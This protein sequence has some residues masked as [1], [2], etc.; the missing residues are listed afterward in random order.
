VYEGRAGMNKQTQAN[1][2]APRFQVLPSGIM[3]NNGQPLNR[4][5]ISLCLPLHRTSVRP[6]IDGSAPV[7]FTARVQPNFDLL[8]LPI[9]INRSLQASLGRTRLPEFF[10]NH[11]SDLILLLLLHGARGDRNDSDI[12][13]HG[14][15]LGFF[16]TLNGGLIS[17]DDTA[18]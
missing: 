18:R 4:G 16:R 13:T 15:Q 10:L 11:L 3:A 2:F 5:N 17:T 14:L 1:R 7:A 8:G 9:S 12:T 6:T